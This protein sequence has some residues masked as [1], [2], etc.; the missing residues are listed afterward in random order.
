MTNF[1]DVFFQ[2]CIVIVV[3]EIGRLAYGLFKTHKDKK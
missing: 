2:C 1:G 3:M